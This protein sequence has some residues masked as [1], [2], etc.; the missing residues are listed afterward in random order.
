MDKKDIF[1]IILTGILVVGIA[2][3][4]GLDG[5]D[6]AIVGQGG[7]QKTDNVD[8][9][10]GVEAVDN[11]ELM[12][13]V[14]CNELESDCNLVTTDELQSEIDNLQTAIDDLSRTSISDLNRRYLSKTS[15]SS[16]SSC[17]DTCDNYGEACMFAFGVEG[18]SDYEYDVPDDRLV[19]VDSCTNP[20][21]MGYWCV[22]AS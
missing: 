10:V 12:T 4:T 8:G 22:C 2:G 21:D 11:A 18:P 13:A 14:S 17:E 3:F 20:R 16:G 7:H 1:V 5:R 15:V 19:L 6:G 9:H